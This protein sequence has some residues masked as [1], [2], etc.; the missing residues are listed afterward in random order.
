MDELGRVAIR[1]IRC[2]KMGSGAGIKRGDWIS[3]LFIA[4]CILKTN[5]LVKELNKR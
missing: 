1:T 5:W 4:S 2:G 3:E